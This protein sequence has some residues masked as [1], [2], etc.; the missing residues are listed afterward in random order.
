MIICFGCEKDLPPPVATFG[1]ELYH[2][3]CSQ[4]AREARGRGH[5]PLAQGWVAAWDEDRYGF[6]H[7][8]PGS[9]PCP[10]HQAL[11]K[12]EETPEI[13]GVEWE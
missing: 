2:S 12:E 6:V 7:K 8:N 10:D 4:K 3:K 13:E 11:A 9:C 5:K 1:G